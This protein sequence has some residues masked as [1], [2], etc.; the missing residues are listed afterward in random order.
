[1][2]PNKNPGLLAVVG[3]H[4]LEPNLADEIERRMLLADVLSDLSATFE[5]KDYADY[6][7]TDPTLAFKLISLAA[8][9]YTEMGVAGSNPTAALQIN[10]SSSSLTVR[11][12]AAPPHDSYHSETANATVATRAIRIKL[13]GNTKPAI[14]LLE[15]APAPALEKPTVEFFGLNMYVPGMRKVDPDSVL[16]PETSQQAA[17][18][19]V[20]VGLAGKIGSGEPYIAGETSIIA[21]RNIETGDAKVYTVTPIERERVETLLGLEKVRFLDTGQPVMHD[22][23]AY[24]ALSNGQVQRVRVLQGDERRAAAAEFVAAAEEIK[25]G[26]APLTARERYAA[27]NPQ[28]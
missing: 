2:G 1:M 7:V 21:V 6:G 9:Q 19:L 11:A 18:R 5:A 20:I 12:Q 24:V 13:G 14:P 10:H 4:D 22:G 28:G 25:S 17:S 27:R 3:R 26:D 8:V 15:V 16:R 23:I